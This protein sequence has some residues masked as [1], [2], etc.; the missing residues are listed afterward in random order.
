MTAS[1]NLAPLRTIR[2]REVLAN[3]ERLFLAC[4][5]ALERAYHGYAHRARCAACLTVEVSGPIPPASTP[6][7]AGRGDP[8]PPNA[9]PPTVTPPPN[10]PASPSP[11]PAGPILPA[12]APTAPEDRTP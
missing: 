6:A 3:R 8:A 11:A 1:L 7:N 12:G 9:A 4:G 2:H 10:T 5:H